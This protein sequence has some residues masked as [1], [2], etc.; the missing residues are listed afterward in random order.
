MK[1]PFGKCKIATLV[2]LAFN[3]ICI[4]AATKADIIVDQNGQGDYKTVTAAISALPMFPYQRT[5]ILVRNGIYE[6]KIRID[7]DYITLRGES[8]DGTIIRYNQLRSDWDEH[9]DAIGPAVVNIFGDDIILDDL[10]VENTQSKIGPHAFA[11][12]GMGTRTLFINC[13]FLSKG[14]DTVSLW[15]NKE[16]MYYHANCYF[17]GAVDFVCPRGWCFIRDSRFYEVRQSAS[18]WHDGHYDSSQKFVILNSYFDGAEG[19]LLGRHHYDAQF[20]LLDC[21]FSKSMADRPIYLQT[22]DDSTKNNPYIYGERKYFV[23]CAKE[24]EPYNWYRNNLDQASG[25]PSPKEITPEWTFNGRWHPESTAHVKIIDHA[26]NGKSLVLTFDEI[27]SVKGNPIFRGNNGQEFQ[28]VKRRYNDINKLE[29]VATEDI[30][31]EDLS[32][33]FILVNGNIIASVATVRE[34]SLKPS[35]QIASKSQEIGVSQ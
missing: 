7:Q 5:V 31:P 32:K 14:A 24:G 27:V 22:Y 19:F 2:T 16:G 33:E 11:V 29:F 25:N 9:P 34:R 15:N 20:Y 10:T 6:E 26:F 1:F 8:R 4:A 21:H 13:N 17:Q 18:L 28:I 30:Q 3:I 35:F 12:Y 23:N